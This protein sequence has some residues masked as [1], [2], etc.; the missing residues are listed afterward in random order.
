MNPREQTP[1]ELRREGYAPTRDYA[2]IGDGRTAAVLARDGTID[3]LCLPDLDSPS[4]FAAA[5]DAT[6][7]GSF[8]LLPEGRF[9]VEH[10]AAVGGTLAP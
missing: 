7:G 9:E 10:R 1:R 4:V 6:R 3:W 8:Y 5:L 2:V